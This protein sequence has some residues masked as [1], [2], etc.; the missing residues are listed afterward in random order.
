MLSKVLS[1]LEGAAAQP[2]VFECIGDP[3]PA[4]SS[5]EGAAGESHLRERISELEQRL[6]TEAKQQYELGWREGEARARAEVQPLLD[7]LNQSVVEVLALRSE[8]RDRAERDTVKLALLIAE[9]VLHRELSVDDG[10]LSAVAKVAFGRMTRS[11]F[12]RVVTHP[13]FVASLTAVL[14][15]G[16]GGRVQIE[17]DPNCAP[18][19]VVIHSAEGTIDASVQTQLEEITR[20]LTDRLAHSR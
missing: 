4:C 9:R 14:P 5:G 10:A 2:A 12:Y 17:P 8:M 20:G 18:G 16:Q 15:A 13:R 1:R 19:T 6:C 3:R 7:R 11:E